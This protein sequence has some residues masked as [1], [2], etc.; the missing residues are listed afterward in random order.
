MH[1]YCFFIFIF[2]E[3]IFL[4]FLFSFQ[5]LYNPQFMI[6]FSVEQTK[7]EKKSTIYSS[8]NSYFTIMDPF[9][10]SKKTTTPDPMAYL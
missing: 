4:S 5:R 9:S 10:H 7:Q 1:N 6:L 2:K 3:D 8:N